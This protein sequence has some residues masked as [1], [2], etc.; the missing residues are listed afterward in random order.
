MRR[1]ILDQ[2]GINYLTLTV[3][4]WTD[5]FT[6]KECKDIIIESLAH[7]IKE[8]GLVIYA[9]VIMSNH[10]HLV[11]Q[12]S[13]EGISLSDILRDFKKFTSRKIVDWIENSGKESR[14][15]WLLHRFAWNAKHSGGNRKYQ[16]WKRNNYPTALW[17]AE[18]IWKKIRYIHRNPIRAAW[19]FE[20]PQYV[21][22]SASNYIQKNSILDITLYEGIV[23]K[24]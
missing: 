9:Y 21:Y 12:A 8:K 15:E 11:A 19:V 4:D 24:T 3:V 1:K 23:Y 22:S 10:I 5:V 13:K 18:V 2:K 7:C 6:R 16:L 20:A 17:S 14:K